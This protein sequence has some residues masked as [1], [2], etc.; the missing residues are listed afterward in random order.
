MAKITTTFLLFFLISTAIYGQNAYEK[1]QADSLQIGAYS[2]TFLFHKPENLPKNPK[3][4]FVL[5]GS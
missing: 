2:R 5:H 4:L 3:L 1:L